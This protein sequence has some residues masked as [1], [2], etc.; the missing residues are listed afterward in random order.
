MNRRLFL[1]ASALLPFGAEAAP[2]EEPRFLLAGDSEA[3]LL[4]RPLRAEARTHRVTL[5]VDARGG[6][7]A[8][9][10]LKRGWFERA[11][12]R[13]PSRMV[14]VS[15]GVNCTRVERPV[16][17]RDVQDLVLIANDRGV[18]LCWLLPPPLKVDTRYLVDA[19]LS[20]G[21]F[22]CAP[23]VLPLESDGVHPT[24]AGC[25]TWAHLIADVLWS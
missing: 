15:L 14:L 22:C 23:D 1:V 19:V 3:Y 17:A 13:R 24:P 11:L 2:S 8:R 6:S 4:A 18:A 9:Q 21:V 16:L 25:K 5:A 10:W 12:A 20:T 7:S